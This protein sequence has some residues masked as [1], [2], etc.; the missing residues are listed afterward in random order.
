MDLHKGTRVPSHDANSKLY[1]STQVLNDIA[2]AR[3]NKEK[4]T[5][6]I[7]LFIAGITVAHKLMHSFV[8]YRAG[9][10]ELRTPVD[11][12]HPPDWYSQSWGESGFALE[13]LLLGV[14]P[15]LIS[16]TV[17]RLEPARPAKF[18]FGYGVKSRLR[19]W[20]TRTRIAFNKLQ[21]EGLV[22]SRETVDTNN[23]K[24]PMLMQVLNRHREGISASLCEDIKT[25]ASRNEDGTGKE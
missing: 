13:A 17:T 24:V 1:D 14:A 2:L 19:L 3:Q 12:S 6:T 21:R 11:V 22:S 18:G 7:F 8:R 15:T 16:R 4:S 23:I 25:R 20:L 5:Y 9:P 10:F